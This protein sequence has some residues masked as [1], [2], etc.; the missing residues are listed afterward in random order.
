M[1]TLPT[2]TYYWRVRGG[3]DS[4]WTEASSGDF[5]P[6]DG[7]EVEV[8]SVGASAPA[9]I[10]A[11][12][13]IDAGT[14][15]ADQSLEYGD[16]VSLSAS[17]GVTGTNPVY[18][19]T[20][21][22]WLSIDSNTGAI[23]G[24][25]PD[26]DASGTATV[27]VRNSKYS[28]TK[29]FAYTVTDPAS[30]TFTGLVGSGKEGQSNADGTCALADV[31][32]AMQGVYDRALMAEFD[33]LGDTAPLTVVKD[34]FTVDGVTGPVAE[35]KGGGQ[36][37]STLF[38]FAQFITDTAAGSPLYPGT[39]G[40]LLQK[41]AIGGQPQSGFVPNGAHWRTSDSIYR[42]TIDVVVRANDVRWSHFDYAQGER[43]AE[44]AVST[45][46]TTTGNS[47]V[48]EVMPLALAD[49][50]VT[51]WAANHVDIIRSKREYFD[52]AATIPYIFLGFVLPGDSG[53]PYADNQE[54]VRE[55]VAA[56]QKSL[57]RWHVRLN[58][59]GDA[60]TV[61]DA[62][63]DEGYV[64]SWNTV[65]D[66]PTYADA[67]A[68]YRD[69]NCYY[70]DMSGYASSDSLHHNTLTHIEKGGVALK[71]LIEHIHG[72]GGIPSA[73]YAVDRVLPV[74]ITEPYVSASTATSRTY[75]FN[76]SETGDIYV[77]AWPESTPQPSAADVKAG[78][79]AS[80]TGTAI[81]TRRVD[82]TVTLSGLTE[83][84]GYEVYAVLG[85][86]PDAETS[87][88]KLAES[89]A[90]VEAT[91]P[92]A[93]ESGDW[94]LTNAGDGDA[95][96]VGISSLPDNGG[97]TITD[98]E[99]RV[100]GGTWT[101]SGGTSGFDI[102]GLTEDVEVDVE[103]RAVNAE[104]EGD[105]S[106]TKSETPSVVAA[107]ASTWDATFE[108][109]QIT[110]SSGNLVATRTASGADNIRGQTP[111]SSGKRY[112]E[113]Y[114]NGSGATVRCG[115]GVTTAPQGTSVS[116]PT[117]FVGLSG[118]NVVHAGGSTAISPALS[119]DN[120]GGYVVQVCIDPATEEFWVRL[121]NIGAALSSNWNSNASADPATGVGGLS[122]STLTSDPVP[123][124][125]MN[126]PGSEVTLRVASGDWDYSAPTGFDPL[127]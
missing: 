90:A 94:T 74:W 58:E 7:D 54:R 60:I 22:D 120:S 56:Q 109:S 62:A 45:A 25:A 71:L 27:T 50:L 36:G 44:L 17:T 73:D 100:D 118:G 70:I 5:D 115:I 88:V 116:E 15:I 46:E 126:A 26:A 20:G 64:T 99:Y 119:G 114:H 86:D 28:D 12:T 108:T 59:A 52:T 48:A 75:T 1:V 87:V 93:F 23:T 4:S 102:T 49:A 85:M 104:G 29:A 77:G 121:H 82:R 32:D 97:A 57:A 37:I 3:A 9:Y 106:D 53:D 38:G 65:D 42:Q 79:G 35:A 66:E 117:E 55:A 98:I 122:Y 63:G 76:A 61:T 110:Y 33:N 51:G 112:F 95:L 19:I 8:V 10:V 69:D 111:V 67:A 24:T 41:R 96:T 18:S 81:A 84:A 72:T 78:T 31:P 91:V 125:S 30:V 40:A 11:D 47:N 16:S 123:M 113:V 101:S 14:A 43:E 68:P 103:I 21:A 89:I 127:P 2:T 107:A 83:G 13:V 39:A 105:P 6:T 124:A 92:D 80:V 34:G